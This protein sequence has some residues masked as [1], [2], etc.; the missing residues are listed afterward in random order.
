MNRETDAL[1]IVNEGHRV[2]RAFLYKCPLEKPTKIVAS[3]CLASTMK[4]VM[5]GNVEERDL[6]W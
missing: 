1:V 2:T 5:K 3:A 4:I 6:R